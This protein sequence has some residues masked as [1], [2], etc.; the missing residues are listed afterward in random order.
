MT[1]TDHHRTDSRL[2]VGTIS[3]AR[4]SEKSIAYYQKPGDRHSLHI[5][6]PE[7]DAWVLSEEM[8][9]R[10]RHRD[11][12][13]LNLSD[14]GIGR[15]GAEQLA[16]RLNSGLRI[17][18]LNLKNCNI[19]DPG[20]K[21][22][23]AALRLNTTVIYL[24]VCGNTI[25]DEGGKRLADMLG[26]LRA[27]P[28]EGVLDDEDGDG[29]RSGGDGDGVQARG[30]ATPHHHNQ[31]L[32]SLDLHNNHVRDDGAKALAAA[33]CT[34]STL[35]S[36]YLGGNGIGE[37]GAVE[38]AEAIR[39][40]TTLATLDLSYNLL[41]ARGANQLAASRRYVVYEKNPAEARHALDL[42]LKGARSDFRDVQ[43]GK[44]E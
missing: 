17:T 37:P 20:A 9:H 40:N 19:G 38:L 18:L 8:V 36:L 29:V 43:G 14:M 15:S 3:Q 6:D 28:L 25:G 7:P 33:L 24:S 32:T 13:E 27:D 41:G 44:G 1:Y 10:L 4:V 35:R 11:E 34:N 31:T 22:L 5:A 21:A 23:A 2:R 42:Q 12:E 16:G 26:V 30:V 39:L